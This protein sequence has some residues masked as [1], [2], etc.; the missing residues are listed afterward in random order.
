[1]N[2]S[3]GNRTELRPLRGV[4]PPLVTPLRSRDELD[5]E[6]LE[7]LI[8]HVV[9]GG[10]H[11]LF[12]LGTTGE[13]PNLG[14]RLRRE[15]IDQTCKIARGRVPVLVGITDTAF[16]ES[17]NLARHAAA[18]GVHALVVSTPYY[19]PIG[20]PELAD[21]LERL[22]AELPLPLFLYNM[23]MMTKVQFEPKL[24]R[25][26]MALD[27]VIGIK[28]SSGDLKY[29]QRILD[30]ARGRPDWSVL[31]GQEHIL[32]EAVRRGAHGGVCGGANIYPKLY[33]S[34]YDAALRG[35]KAQEA[36]LM[37][38]VSQLGKIYKIGKYASAIVKSIK[39]AL[40]VNGICG[41]CLAEPFS[42]FHPAE[43]EQVRAV[44]EKVDHLMAS[45]P[46]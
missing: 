10:V 5:K 15:L 33:V 21:Y 7:R 39:C 29:F 2:T 28:D 20:Q 27:R 14:Y 11:G 12:I 18:A 41:D 44:L 19:F 40:S 9:A 30:L 35:D 16:V 3:K 1:M 26:M 13:A 45:A 8:E 24:V 17:V 4:I 36:A 34:L 32:P 43:R 23:P 46:R 37:K 22:A 38:Q 6:G 25:R 31:V 42:P